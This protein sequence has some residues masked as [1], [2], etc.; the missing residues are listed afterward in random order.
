[1]NQPWLRILE[2]IISIA[3]WVRNPFQNNPI[4]LSLEDE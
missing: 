2:S 1:M 4:D 3:E